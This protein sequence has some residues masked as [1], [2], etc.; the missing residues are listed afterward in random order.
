MRL[1]WDGSDRNVWLL[2]LYVNC[3]QLYYTLQANNYNHQMM[4]TPELNAFGVG[5]GFGFEHWLH[6]GAEWCTPVESGFEIMTNLN[7]TNYP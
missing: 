1:Q 6:H 5:F 7:E 2:C 3:T 4:I